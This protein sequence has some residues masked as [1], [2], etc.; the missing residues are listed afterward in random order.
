LLKEFDAK[1]KDSFF[2][3]ETFFLDQLDF[4]LV[5]SVLDI[6]CACGRFIDLLRCHYGYFG[7]YT[8]LDI[9]VPS[10]QQCKKNY[11][12]AHFL[13]INALN[14]E[15]TRQFYLVNATGVMQHEP[16]YRLLIQKM[17]Q[18]SKRFVLFDVKLAKIKEEIIDINRCYCQ[19]KG[20]RIPIIPLEL[21][22]LMN[23]LQVMPETGKVSIMGY[24]T[25]FNHATTV[26]NDLKVWVSAGVMIDKQ[27]PFSVEVIKL[28][29]Y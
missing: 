11:S 26:P 7:H 25:P 23:Y 21:T 1:R 10:I 28:P 2:L 8:G 27:Q 12:D 16:Q 15:S 17:L 14:F 18:L 6:G 24:K 20:E 19:S 22:S 9:S 5:D 3:S 13:N 4:E 29:E